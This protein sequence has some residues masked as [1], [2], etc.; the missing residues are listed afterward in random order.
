MGGTN[1]FDNLA[2]THAKCNQK[3]GCHSWVAAYT[4]FSNPAI[5]R[6]WKRYMISGYLPALHKLSS[7][8]SV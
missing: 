1:H 6:H 5:R 7:M 4:F 2:L 3:R 8:N